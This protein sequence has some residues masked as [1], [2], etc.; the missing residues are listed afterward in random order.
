MVTQKLVTEEGF[1]TVLK[2]S[3]MQQEGEFEEGV[4]AEFPDATD[5]QISKAFSK[6]QQFLLKKSGY[7]QIGFALLEE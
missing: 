5:E 4:R 3:I 1:A 2:T 7:E 6:V